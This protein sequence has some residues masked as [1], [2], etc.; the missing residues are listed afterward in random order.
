MSESS[1]LEIQQ[2]LNQKYSEL[3]QQLGS[4]SY[5][6]GLLG[7]QIADINAQIKSLNSLA[8]VMC[9]LET[10]LKAK[11]A[12]DLDGQVKANFAAG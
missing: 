10:D 4:L 5:Q 8:P 2:N 11:L 9:K 12:K 3:C 6:H 1:P 7:A